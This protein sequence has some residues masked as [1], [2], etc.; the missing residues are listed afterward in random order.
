VPYLRNW[1]GRAG[2]A[3]RPG[4][5]LRRKGTPQNSCFGTVV[6]LRVAGLF[7]VRHNATFMVQTGGVRAGYAVFRIW[8]APG[9]WVEGG[10]PLQQLTEETHPIS[11]EVEAEHLPTDDVVSAKRRT[12]ACDN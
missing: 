1:G 9:H 3:T 10:E 4:W 8:Q 6:V 2:E 11:G 12:V 7:D 5:P